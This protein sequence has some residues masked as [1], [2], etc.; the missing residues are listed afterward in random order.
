MKYRELE[1]YLRELGCVPTG[2]SR[3]KHPE[4]TNPTNGLKTKLSHHKSQEV[5][6]G[7]LHAILK[8]LGLK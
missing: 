3:A 5:P 1:D 6:P 4:W 2:K 8:G 7:T